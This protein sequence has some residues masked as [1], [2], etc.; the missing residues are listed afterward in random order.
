[1]KISVAQTRPI[2]G[3]L[4]ANIAR[5][6]TLIELAI[7]NQAGLVIFP[8]L[9][10]T[11]Y[12]PVL[13]KE[14]ATHAGDRR[15]DDF[16]MISDTRQITIGIGVPTKHESGI[17]ISLVIFQPHQPRQLYSK[18]YLHADEEPFF[19][20]GQYSPGLIGG[21]ANIALAIC[22]E[23]LVPEH[24]EHAHRSGAK[25][26]IASVA[27]TVDG[28]NKAFQTL[29]D[30][31]RKYSMPVLMANAIGPCDNFECAGKSAV[32]NQQGS[33]LGQLDGQHEGLLIFDTETQEIVERVI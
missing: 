29:P 31:A 8:E 27:K 13:A 19:V 26:Y 1:M 10:I 9:S 11:G 15:F 17:C 25:I 16:Q 2:K 23:L 32:W 12:E 21:P 30:T 5:H 22:Y 14:L 3:N 6:Q 4:Q 24:A 7:A 20:S 18:K 28:V 33:L